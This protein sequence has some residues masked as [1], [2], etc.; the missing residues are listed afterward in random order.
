MSKSVKIVTLAL[1]IV[2]VGGMVSVVA[3][4]LGTRTR[5]DPEIYYLP[6]DEPIEAPDFT[7]TDQLGRAVSASDLK[8]HPWIA[9][10]IFTECAAI[11][12]VMT[13][14][15]ASLQSRIPAE[16]KF[17]SFS[18]DP[19]HDLPPVLLKYANEYGADNDRWRFLTGK[20]EDVM[21]T[22]KGMKVSF[23]PASKD[24][25]IDHDTHFLLMDSSGRLH[26]VYSGPAKE[27]MDKLVTDATAL[28]AGESKP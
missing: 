27:D 19:A 14:N 15:L 7:L 4:Q 13:H 16:V 22:V 1:W 26:G 3:M 5:Q 24:N 6:H 11:C 28:V 18:V 21:A 17:I 10:F 23:I 25:P 20:P 8:G 9:D 12:P 2:A